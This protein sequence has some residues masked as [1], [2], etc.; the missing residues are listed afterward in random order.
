MAGIWIAT[1]DHIA[2]RW[3][4]QGKLLKDLDDKLNS[5]YKLALAAL[6]E[7]DEQDIRKGREQLRKSQR[8][9]LAY[10]RAQCDL[11]GGLQGGSNSWVSTFAG[12]CQEKEFNSRI[13]FLQSVADDTFGE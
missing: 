5:V 13:A 11:E 2:I 6:P 10:V 8:A 3:S 1:G 12:L 9:W 7:K 4:A